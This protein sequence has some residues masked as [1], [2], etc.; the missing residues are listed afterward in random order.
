MGAIKEYLKIAIKSLRTRPTRSWLTMIGVVIGIFLII[1]LL[2]LSEGIKTAAM[3]Q[4]RMM[5]KDLIM[6]MHGE[7]TDIVATFIGGME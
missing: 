1:S 6:I 3:Q 7:L 4:L 2:S 5:G